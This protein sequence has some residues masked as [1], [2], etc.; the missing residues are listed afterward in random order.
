MQQVLQR[1]GI[2]EHLRGRGPQRRGPCPVPGHHHT[3]Q[4]TFSVHLGNNVFH[5]FDA[6]CTAHGNVLD[7]WAAVHRLPIYEAALHLAATFNL[8]V[9]REEEPVNH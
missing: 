1:L 8:A 7:L 2:L 9:N 5:C 4:R 3:N 6:N